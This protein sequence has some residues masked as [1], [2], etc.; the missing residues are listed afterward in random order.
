[1]SQ[2]TQ[3]GDVLRAFSSGL[4]ATIFPRFV[5]DKTSSYYVL[6]RALN[7]RDTITFTELVIEASTGVESP[8]L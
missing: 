2:P 5:P 3:V 7:C 8:F 4:T 1:M 6:S